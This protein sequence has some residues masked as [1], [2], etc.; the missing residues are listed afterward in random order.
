L[1]VVLSGETTSEG[2]GLGVADDVGDE[3]VEVVALTSVELL[4][5]V[6]LYPG[7]EKLAPDGYHSPVKLQYQL[8]LLGF[9]VMCHGID[10]LYPTG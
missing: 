9:Q 5:S 2:V 7:M 10:V 1:L 4:G 3:T 8:W 6:K